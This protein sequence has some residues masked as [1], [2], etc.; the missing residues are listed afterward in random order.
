MISEVSFCECG[1]LPPF[2]GGRIVKEI[3]SEGDGFPMPK[4]RV[5]L[6]CLSMSQY[7]DGFP[8]IPRFHRDP[9]SK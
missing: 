7:S 4:A 9:S 3:W 1:R 6:D 2:S 8:L 5:E